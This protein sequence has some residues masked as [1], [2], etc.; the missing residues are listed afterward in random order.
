M[1]LKNFKELECWK[2][3]RQLVKFVYSI[4]QERKFSKDYGLKAQIQRAAVSIMSNIAE[5]FGSQSDAEFI[6]FLSY[7][8]R[9]GYE[10]QT[11]LCV[12]NDVGYINLSQLE[13]GEAL[14]V[15]CIKMCKS[16]VRYLNQAKKKN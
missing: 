14:V 12:A 4:T 8:I 13:K 10:V 15:V 16:L 3:S 11:H 5:G 7:S 2:N 9:S 6:R 1:K